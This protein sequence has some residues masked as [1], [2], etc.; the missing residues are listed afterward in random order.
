MSNQQQIRA[1]LEHN[2]EVMA[3]Y[4]HA[5]DILTKVEAMGQAV[6]RLT[7]DFM[8]IEDVQQPPPHH[9]GPSGENGQSCHPFSF[10]RVNQDTHVGG[11][12]YTPKLSFPRFDGQ[13][14]KIW[15]DKCL[16]Y[17]HVCN[18]PEHLWVTTASLHMDDNAASWLQMFK[19]TH[20]LGSWVEFI[21]AVEEQFGFDD[22]RSALD[23]LLVLK[24]R[25]T[26]EEYA[27]EFESLQF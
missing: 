15:K 6:A 9:Q 17:F 13:H 2:A 3:G 24:Q 26:V 20:G 4:G 5:Q 12:S 25:G 27:T 8:R 21:H 14:P 10:G 22:Y 18:V 23:E 11:R 7:T 16:N 19:L 1:Q